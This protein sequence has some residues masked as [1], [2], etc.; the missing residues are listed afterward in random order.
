[1]K[2]YLINLERSI[3]RRSHMFSQLAKF[4]PEIPIERALCKDIKNTDWSMP[5]GIQPGYWKSDRWAL[6]PSDIEI[7][8]S[9]IDCWKKISESGQIGIVLEDDLIFSENFQDFIEILKVENLDGIIRLDGVNLPLLID[10]Y[11]KTNNKFSISK[12]NSIVASAAAYALDPVTAEKLVANVKVERTVDDY[13]FDPTP[14][15]RG[16]KGHGLPIYQLEPIIVVQAQFGTYSDVSRKAPAFLEVTKR[17]DVKHRK[18]RSLQ[19]PMLYRF[20]KEII[21]IIYKYR[22]KKR[23]KNILANMGEWS[24][25]LLSKDLTWK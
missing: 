19:G 17:V 15:D 8:R 16:A 12:V 1:M 21:R 20:K 23:K 3:D 9:H 14:K 10:K 5:E 25:P 2:I 11:I 24:K 6:A 7:F 4:L 13:L 22:L 18:L